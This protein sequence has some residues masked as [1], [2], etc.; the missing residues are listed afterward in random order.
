[1]GFDDRSG[2]HAAQFYRGSPRLAAAA[3]VTVTGGART[4][5]INAAL[6]QLISR[7][8]LRSARSLSVSASS[9]VAIKLA[10]SGT[11]PCRGTATLTAQSGRRTAARSLVIGT[12]RISLAAGRNAALGIRLNRSGRSLLTHDGGRLTAGLTLAGT[13]S[14]VK[15]HQSS[16]V[17][18]SGVPT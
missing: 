13:P 8:A 15:F 4:S 12:A 5:A 2:K 17:R 11:G 14:G 3:M 9:M 6:K 16:Q 7:L 10:C 1:V 18:L